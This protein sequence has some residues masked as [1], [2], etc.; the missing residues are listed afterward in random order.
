MCGVGE[1]PLLGLPSLRRV[2]FSHLGTRDFGLRAVRTWAGDAKV[3]PF[4]VAG[5]SKH[6]RASASAA[7]GSV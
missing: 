4:P 2:S 5:D 6:V 1:S 7:P 3:N